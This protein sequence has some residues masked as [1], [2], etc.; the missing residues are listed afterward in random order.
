M[1]LDWW[2]NRGWHSGEEA[3]YRAVHQCYGGSVVTD[4]DFITTVSSLASIPINFMVSRECDA[5]GLP[6]AAVA[7]WGTYVAGTKRAAQHFG[8]RDYVDLG[9]SE[10]ILPMASEYRGMMG[11]RCEY[12]SA[13]HRS[14]L[15]NARTMSSSL[16]LAKGIH[17]GDERVS[18]KLRKSVRRYQRIF[19]QQGGTVTPV[20]ELSAHELAQIYRRLFT[21]YRNKPPGGDEHLERTY[22]ALR[23]FMTGNILLV[24]NEPVAVQILYRATS[25]RFLS[26]EYI[27]GGT[28]PDYAELNPGTLLNYYNVSEIE[29]DAEKSGLQMHY[30]FGRFDVDY[31]RR[32]CEAVTALRC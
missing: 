21:L 24:K 15:R 14:N 18:N 10:V 26:V 27:N 11:Y 22:Q 2:R 23:S 31:K 32:W 30:S 3:D 6:L 7:L 19:E 28:H 12:L 8:V 17:L 13:L 20:G 4:P 5:N 25:R 9:H 29:Q 16:A 1:L